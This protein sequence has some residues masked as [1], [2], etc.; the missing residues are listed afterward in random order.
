M[1]KEKTGQSHKISDGWILQTFALQFI[2][3]R[4]LNV[5]WESFPRLVL[6]LHARSWQVPAFFWN[7]SQNR[8]LPSFLLLLSQFIGSRSVSTLFYSPTLSSVREIE[9]NRAMES[10]SQCSL[11]WPLQLP[12]HEPITH[13]VRHP[14]LL[15]VMTSPPPRGEGTF[16]PPLLFHSIFL[17]PRLF[18]FDRANGGALKW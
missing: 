4:N 6:Q 15:K 12:P 8:S 1:W 14:R 5:L 9:A 16:L 3:F 11:A 10:E 7:R 13:R 2:N 18:C 17:G